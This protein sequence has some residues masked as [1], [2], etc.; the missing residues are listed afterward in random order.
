MKIGI[1]TGDKVTKIVALFRNLYN[2]VENVNIVLSKD[3][4][5]IQGMNSTHV[6]LVEV[7]IKSDWFDS[8]DCEDEEIAVNTEMLFK[9]MNS[10]S[11]E[12]NI[13]LSTSDSDKLKINLT[14]KGKISK[15]YELP[16]IML[17]GENIN[18]PDLE[19]DVDI[20]LKSQELR[21]IVNEVVMFDSDVNLKCKEDVIK[22]SSEGDYGKVTMDIKEGDILEYSV[23]IEEGG[24][25]NMKLHGGYLL[26]C[27]NLNKINKSV[28][29]HITN[30]SPVKICYY[31]EE[32]NEDKDNSVT[33]FI[34][35]GLDEE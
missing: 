24:E 3:N 16:I 34:A 17:D 15:C 21:D 4:L 23:A 29:I 19:Y 31:L 14:G 9:V 11:E 10:W 7:R 30:E 32:D 1:S 25:I 12:Y 26:H 13:E 28:E 27:C 2:I 22:I 33:F 20:T 6:C 18:T 8:F 5:Y 35:P